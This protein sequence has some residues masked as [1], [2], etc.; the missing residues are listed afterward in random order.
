MSALM[1]KVRTSIKL[2]RR[3]SRSTEFIILLAVYFLA[4]VGL[5]S[6][7]VNASAWLLLP[8]A[9]SLIQE[10]KI[11]YTRFLALALAAGIIWAADFNRLFKSDL[12]YY[13]LVFLILGGAVMGLYRQNFSRFEWIFSRMYP[14]LIVLVFAYPLYLHF[15]ASK[16]I[17][18]WSNLQLETQI[19]PPFFRESSW[20]EEIRYLYTENFHSFFS[21]IVPAAFIFALE[22]VL[23]FNLLVL[24]ILEPQSIK[25][26]QFW[27][28]FSRWKPTDWVLLPLVI[29]LGLLA[30]SPGDIA[31]KEWTWWTWVG[32]NITVLSLFPI[33]LNGLSFFSYLLPRMGLF[34]AL[35]SILLFIFLNPFPVLIVAGWADIWFDFRRRMRS[36]PKSD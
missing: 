30:V 2:R 6:C 21:M 28:Q 33:S 12:D 16:P 13:S 4:F 20:L 10:S 24:R 29:G 14:L 35:M 31:G 26:A 15:S 22:F 7:G 36:N 23:I 8:A 9:Y 34:F 5:I 11:P 25:K 17:Q 19:L 18:D 27:G 3:S 1:M 32:W